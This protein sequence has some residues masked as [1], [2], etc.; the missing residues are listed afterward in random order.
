MLKR[1]PPTG[2]LNLDMFAA[3]LV[4][5]NVIIWTI[6]FVVFIALSASARATRSAAFETSLAPV[7]EWVKQTGRSTVMRGPVLQALGFPA[8]D[9]RVVERGFRRNKEQFTHV[10]S[11]SLEPGFEGTVFLAVVDENDGSALVW[12]ANRLGELIT[13]AHFIAGQAVQASNAESQVLFASEKRYHAQEMRLRSFRTKAA[14]SPSPLAS[15]QPI[16]LNGRYTSPTPQRAPR[17]WQE[18]VV[19]LINPWV[20]P[21]L[22]LAAV[23]GSSKP[24]RS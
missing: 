11:L 7:A 18:L 6:F 3:L 4:Q 8:I 14:P 5:W 15:P 9:A 2:S 10:C 21:A 12:R 24:K 19:L 16:D 17:V 22:I 23:I 20:V 1:I 13:S